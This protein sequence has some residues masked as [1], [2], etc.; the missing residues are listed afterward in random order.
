MN[1]GTPPESTSPVQHDT[2]TGYPMPELSREVFAAEQYKQQFRDKLKQFAADK[3]PHP[4]PS[5]KLNI[6]ARTDKPG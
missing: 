6:S 3:N 2:N 5:E 1:S 4:K